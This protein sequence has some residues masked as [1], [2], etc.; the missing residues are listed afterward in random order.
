[1]ERDRLV[2]LRALM[3]REGI[4][5]FFVAGLH[6]IRYLTGFKPLMPGSVQRFSDP[7]ALV[8][9]QR[10]S[11]DVLC[12]GRY[13]ESVSRIEGITPHRLKS[14]VTA[15]SIGDT[16]KEIAAVRSARIGFEEDALVYAD[17]VALQQATPDITWHPSSHIFTEQRVIKTE[18]EV[19]MLKKAQEITGKGFE[20]IVNWIRPGVS[21]RETAIELHNWLSSHSEGFAFEAI[22]AFGET[23]S[24]PHYA[25]SQSRQIRPGHMALLDF[26]ALWEG[27]AGDLTRMIV[28]GKAD[29]RLRKIY[30]LVRS[31]QE[32]CIQAIKAGRICA[33]LD[34]ICRDHFG[35]R[36]EAEAFLHSTGHG[37][38][39]AVHEEPYIKKANQTR[40]ESGMVFTVEP[41]L[42]YSG[43]G[44]VRIEDVVLAEETGC[45]VL[46][47]VPHD[48]VE[49][50]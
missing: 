35:A 33:D 46:T 49:I 6:N 31:A 2:R 30:D 15:A 13:I 29:G 8:F 27:Y 5:A 37:I 14:P 16:L 22:V 20:H 32:K 24:Q 17:A 41:G 9:V 11:C 45:R 10:D 18:L 4:D 3:D 44:G 43:W 7:E 28:M 38:G 21:E 23:C 40:V 42:Y 12:D 25:P 36:G 39:L 1:M 50:T 47:S 34:A 19:S 48:L 26:G